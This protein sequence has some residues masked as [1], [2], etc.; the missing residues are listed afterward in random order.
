MNT[1]FGSSTDTVIIYSSNTGVNLKGQAPHVRHRKFTKWVEASKPQWKLMA[2]IP[3]KYTFK[4]DG[5]IGSF[6]DFYIY[7]LQDN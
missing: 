6:A 2:H 1:L 3:N 7:K 4:G 5:K